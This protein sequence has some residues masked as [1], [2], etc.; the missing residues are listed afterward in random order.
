[1][2]FLFSLGILALG[3]NVEKLEEGIIQS[4]TLIQGNYSY[5]Y[6]ILNDGLTVDLGV[7]PLYGDTDVY[8]DLVVEERAEK[9]PYPNKKD[10]QYKSASPVVLETIHIQQ[11]AIVKHGKALRISILCLSINCGFSIY[12][13]QG[14]H[15]I[16]ADNRPMQ[17][18]GIR[19][20]FSY[21]R[22]LR[23]TSEKLSVILSVIGSS[24]PALYVSYNKEPTKENHDYFSDTL[25]GE[26]LIISD[27][28]TGLYYIG[29]LCD[30][31]CEFTVT[32]LPSLDEFLP[33]YPGLPQYM[34][35]TDNSRSLFYFWNYDKNSIEI[36]VSVLTGKVIILANPHLPD[37][38][39]M[40]EKI[41]TN[42][43]RAWVSIGKENTDTSISI[44]ADDEKLCYE[45]N[46]I[47]SVG[48]SAGSRYIITV[49]NKSYLEVINNGVP[50]HGFVDVGEMDSFMFKLDSSNDLEI[51]LNVLSGDAD[52]YISTSI[53][54]SDS[55][56]EWKTNTQNS[57]ESILISM[58][59]PKWKIG[60]FYM[61][62]KGW[63]RSTYSLVVYSKNSPIFIDLGL[64]RRYNLNQP[65]HFV[66]G[67][68]PDVNYTCSITDIKGNSHPK[69]FI[70]YNFDGKKFP[71]I[72]NNDIFYEGQGKIFGTSSFSISSSTYRQ[73]AFTIISSTLSQDTMITFTCT[74]PY[75]IMKLGQNDYTY[76]K[77]TNKTTEFEISV[78]TTHDIKVTVYFCERPIIA[79]LSKD[80]TYSYVPEIFHNSGEAKEE[81]LISKTASKYFLRITSSEG[82]SV[83]IFTETVTNDIFEM[84]PGGKILSKET[85]KGFKISWPKALVNNNVNGKDVNYYL[86]YGANLKYMILNYCSLVGQFE[87]GAIGVVDI[88]KENKNEMS[89]SSGAIITVAAVFERHRYN[90]QGIT[91]Y[92]PIEL[93]KSSSS[94]GSKDSYWVYVAI[95]VLLILTSAALYKFKISRPPQ[96]N[97]GYELSNY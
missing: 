40:H 34:S 69:T 59:D 17:A 32:V 62:V 16:L 3:L 27:G 4:G 35:T 42:R 54:V 41:P 52:L 11:S 97:Q 66:L 33:L 86:F 64:A 57:I 84:K 80:R 58:D 13:D 76:Y 37:I 15:P 8:A 95:L 68:S 14:K 20:Q 51:N 81:F 70:Y 28:K 79:E 73:S 93:G 36:K 88:E 53:P 5:F 49:N 92:D 44:D 23:N 61:V 74:D 1:M 43:N 87:S 82:N 72:T 50:V 39:E 12:F 9:F 63:K 38:E 25:V 47:I 55:L 91:I 30:Y 46:I 10:Y 96:R 85:S 94:S 21:F 75:T 60:F 18:S 56:Y 24:N 71:S 22:Y 19:N 31:K 89:L 77:I 29:V 2:I 83:E 26:T 90:S 45:C 78:S 6:A 7:Q 65:L 48:S 67:Q